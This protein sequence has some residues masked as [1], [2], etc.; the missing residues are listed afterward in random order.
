MHLYGYIPPNLHAIDTCE[1]T[2]FA[3]LEPTPLAE[4]R[5][6]MKSSCRKLRQMENC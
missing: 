6:W 2:Y 1:V 3:E 4:V 5:T